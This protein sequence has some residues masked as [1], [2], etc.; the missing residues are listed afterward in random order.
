[1]RAR[2]RHFNAR[3]FGANLVLD[4]RFIDQ[5]DNTAVTSW[6]DRSGNSNNADQST[7][8]NQPTF[9]TNEINGNPV[10]QF[11]GASIPNNDFLN[12]SNPIEL[13][14]FE[15][16][17]IVNRA[18]S[19]QTVLL[20]S[21]AASGSRTYVGIYGS[22]G[23]C[24]QFE[25]GAF[26]GLL[27]ENTSE[28]SIYGFNNSSFFKNLTKTNWSTA[29]PNITARFAR[30]GYRVASGERL[31]GKIGSLF[32]FPNLTESSRKRVTHAAAFSFKISCN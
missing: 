26:T 18:A 29:R 11:D 21:D 32:I 24:I 6:I 1:M 23:A 31:N 28:N 4:A 8:A 3:G 20:A 19:A 16:I 10:V 13:N 15:M 7:V 12:I 17:G 9:Q 27:T 25:N 2:Q 14:N 22:L 5:S 30:V